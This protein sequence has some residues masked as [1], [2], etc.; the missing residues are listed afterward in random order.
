MKKGIKKIIAAGLILASS[1]GLVGCVGAE[2]ELK[3]DI[4]GEKEVYVVYDT[5]TIEGAKLRIYQKNE[6]FKEMRLSIDYGYVLP[7]N[8]VEALGSNSFKAS[9]NNGFSVVCWHFKSN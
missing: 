7:D 5:F 6:T 3:Y 4:I 1:A 8:F 2:D 9:R